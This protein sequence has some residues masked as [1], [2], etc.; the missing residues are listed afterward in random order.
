MAPVDTAVS[1]RSNSLPIALFGGQVFLVAVLTSRVLF[2]TWRAAK[3][4]PPSTRT[5]SQDPA[6]RRHAITFSIIALLSLLSVG[7]FAFLW[8]AISYVRW[9]EHNKHDIPG[10]LWSGSYGA[11]EG[12]WHLGDW[13]ADIDLVREFD[14]VGIMKPEGFLYTSQYFVGLIASTIFM[15]AEGRRR[16][17]SNRTIASFVLLSSIGSLGYALSLFFITILYTPLTIHHDDTPLHDALFTPHAWVYDVGIVASLLTLNLFPQLV[18]E[19]GDKSMLRLG[20]LAMPIAF[21]FAP[22]LVPYAL[23]HQHTSKAAAHRSYAKVFHALSIASIL[24]FWRVLSTLVYVNRPSQRSHVWDVFTNSIGKSDSNR[25]LTSIGNAGQA[26]KHISTHPAISV[27]SLDVLFTGISLL[28]W[29]FT[30]D[31]DVHAILESSV[32]SFLVP[33]H[34]KH[35]TFQEDLSRMMEHSD[36]PSPPLETTTPR[37]RG[38]PSRKAAVHGT[39]TGTHSAPTTA[40]LRRSARGKAH[41]ADVD[42]D[43]GSFA[44]DPDA[45]YQ[46]SEQTKREVEEMEADGSGL[47]SDLVSAGESTALALF[48]AF[49]GGLGQLAAGTLGAEVTGPRD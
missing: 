2:T 4:Q 23:G 43:A 7:S 44:G 25:L 37:K 32:L 46:P 42:A 18:S 16:N 21:A 33:S 31:L 12:R 47:D 35:V 5:R 41:S 36:E 24:V 13:I 38:R 6:R 30:R 34:S 1:S 26:M 45:T 8:R 10:S 28:T 39:S 40:A 9:A 3:S 17:L 27:T 15:G 20:Y 49:F 19:F 48:L 11:D 14:A 22:Q 29:T